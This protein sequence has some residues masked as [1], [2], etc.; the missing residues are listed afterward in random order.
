M[1]SLHDLSLVILNYNSAGD[2]L[3]CVEKLLSFRS[4]FHIIVVD[5]LSTDDSF[6]VIGGAMVDADR[7]Y[8]PRRSGFDIPSAKTIALY[9]FIKFRKRQWKSQV[10]RMVSGKEA[11]A[12]GR[13]RL[14]FL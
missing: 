14:W 12:A 3:F 11:M 6:A 13:D 1:E 8:D 7:T 2:T 9:Q 5:N 10:P 4:D